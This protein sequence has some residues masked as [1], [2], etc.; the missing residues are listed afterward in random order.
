MIGWSTSPR[1]TDSHL[2]STGTHAVK[3]LRDSG[4][5]A[6]IS[7]RDL[8][9]KKLSNGEWLG[10]M[11]EGEIDRARQDESRDMSRQSDGGGNEP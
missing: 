7:G 8:D 4:D 6:M 5:L 11:I 9:W 1:R 2:N 3:F 10:I